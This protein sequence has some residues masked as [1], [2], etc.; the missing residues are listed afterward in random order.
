MPSQSR[1]TSFLLGAVLTIALLT[2]EYLLLLDNDRI[3]EQEKLQHWG[4]LGTELLATRLQEM[5]DRTDLLAQSLIRQRHTTGSAINLSELAPTVLKEESRFGGIGIVRRIGPTQRAE[6]E[7]NIANSIRMLKDRHLTPSPQQPMYYPV[8]S[9][10]PDDGNALPQ[11][12]DLGSLDNARRK[13]DQA[14]NRNQPMLM[15]NTLTPGAIPRLD[16]MANLGDDGHMLLVN[17]RSD[18]LLQSSQ[19]NPDQPNPLQ[20]VRLVVWNQEA[21]DHPSL[22]SLPMQPLP[23]GNPLLTTRRQIGG[24]DLLFGAYPL[25]EDAPAL[26]QQGYAILASSAFIL[27]LL[28]ILQQRQI[29]HNRALRTLLRRQHQQLELNNRTLREQINDRTHSEQALAESEARQRAILQASSDAIILIN[30]KGLITH[31]NPAAAKLI[32]QSAESIEHLPVGSLLTELYSLNV[33]FE[34][35]A[36][37]REGRPFEAHLL[38]SDNRQMPVELSLSRV[39][40]PDDSFYV[41]VCRDISLRKEQEAA[42]IRLK[43]SLAEQVEVQ[44][45]QLAALL[46]ASPMAMAYIVDRHLRRVNGAFLDLF[47]RKED[48]VIGQTTLPYFESQEQWERTGRALYNLLNDGKVVQSEVKLRTGSGKLIWCRMFGRAVNPSVPKLG[49]IWLY[50]DFSAQRE[51]EDALRQAK[52]LAEENS[53]AKTEFLANMSHELRTPMHAILGFTEIGEARSRQLQDDK[54]AQYFQRIHSSGNR[55]LQ[56]LND[57]LDLAKMEVGKMD[58]HIAHY[59]LSHCLREACD[60]MTPLAGSRNIKIYLYC[61]PEKLTADIDP[62]RLGQVVR[63][64]LSNAIKFSPDGEVIR[65]TARLQKDEQ[66][67]EQVMLCV[68]NYGPGIPCDEIETIFDKFIQSSATKTGAGGTG[69]G[70]A[71]CREIIQAHHGVIFAENLVPRGAAFTALLPRFHNTSGPT[72]EDH[73]PSTFAR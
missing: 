53:R 33:D 8:E 63:N 10:L 14:R 52:T 9:Y 3:R 29:G 34:S 54:L 51:M 71:I 58:Y 38:C 2:A 39:E 13:M 55:L 26:S 40:V 1:L 32:G 31:V 11:G 45:R 23:S 60:E 62:F 36:A 28:L 67:R 56:L 69:L 17:L 59:D 4:E 64:L 30:R 41:A 66:Q 48:E 43:N 25:E 21:P 49:T 44:S 22:D 47:E 24:Y 35:I 70:L 15:F 37:A 42:L 57:L 50:Q 5:L 20:H 7:S 19:S 12:M 46:E 27:C 72:G 16:I 18:L 73:V 68:E 65:V 6:F 61:T